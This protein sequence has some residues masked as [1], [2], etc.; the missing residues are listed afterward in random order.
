[1]KE[2]IV[3]QQHGE[4][5]LSGDLYL[6]PRRGGE[7][8]PRPAVLVV[9]GGGWA[10]RSGEMTGIC[11]KLRRAGFAAFNITYRLAPEHRHPSQMEDVSAAL[12]WL[13]ANAERYHIDPSNISGW[14]YSAGAHL[15]LMA[16]LNRPASS[17]LTGIV[18]G[19]T[20]ADLSLWPHSPLVNGLLGQPL[21][22]AE[23]LWRLAS[24]VNAVT[25]SSPPVFLY[26]GSRDTLVE[27][28]QMQLMEQALTAAEV[29]VETHALPWLGHIGT[30]V[31]GFSAHRRAI[32][33]LQ[34]Q[35]SAE[36]SASP[37]GDAEFGA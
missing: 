2:Q 15:I 13:F 3:F 10:R 25:A 35:L 20:P 33:F 1:M 5:V 26:H 37:V 19:G 18:A 11:K 27:P 8:R 12:D 14:G 30:Y 7:S 24:P 6:P 34:R 17:R 22:Q 29:E 21:D 36:Q 28:E 9:H 16:G 4:Q 23:A 32:A 31:L